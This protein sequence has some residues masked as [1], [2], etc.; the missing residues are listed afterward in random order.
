MKLNKNSKVCV[1]THY[2]MDGQGAAIVIS[3][4]FNDVNIISATFTNIDS[5]ISKNIFDI[6][7]VVFMTDVYPKNQD[8]LDIIPNLILLDHHCTNKAHDPLKHRFVVSDVCG[9]MLTKNYCESVFKVDLSHLNNLVYLIN[10]YDLWIHKNKKSKMLNQLYTKYKALKFRQRFINGDTRFSKTELSYIREQINVFNDQYDNLEVFDLD[11]INACF[12][13]LTNFSFINDLCEKL[14]KDE[15]YHVV[16]CQNINNGNISVR[17]NRSDINLGETFTEIGL[18]GGHQ[19]AAG[20]RVIDN[21]FESLK[22]VLKVVEYELLKKY[23][24]LKK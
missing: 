19:M 9:T 4:I 1:I 24:Q 20:I 6:Y 18:G 7:D 2:D 14:L 3:N 13:T 22:S 16:F 5:I 23:P 17:T 10:D 12:F 21:T 11:K 8:L 15:H